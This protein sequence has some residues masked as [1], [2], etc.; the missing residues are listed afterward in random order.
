MELELVVVLNSNGGQYK[1]LTLKTNS[2]CFLL[3]VCCLRQ[4]TR[5]APLHASFN[6]GGLTSACV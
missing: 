4:L 2:T 6:S 3:A 1:A 5:G